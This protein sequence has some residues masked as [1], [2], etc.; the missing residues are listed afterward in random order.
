M[1]KRWVVPTPTES[2]DEQMLM[3]LRPQRLDEYLGQRAVVERLR[4][5][6]DAAKQRGEPLEHTLLYGPPGLGKTTLAHIVANELGV[7]IITTAAPALERAGDVMGYLLSLQRGEVLFVDEVHR[8]ARPVEEFLYPV[9]ESFRVDFNLSKRPGAKPH[10]F[11]LPAF[12]FIGATTTAGRLSKPLRDRFGLKFRLE[13]YGVDELTQIVQRAAQLLGVPIDVDGAQ[14]IARR[15]RGTPRIA[16]RLLRR[17]RDFAQVKGDG[18]ITA[19]VA[20]QALVLEGIDELGLDQL[21]RDYL[22]ALI[23][24]FGGGPAGLEALAALLQEDAR[25]LEEMVEP[26][27]L[28]IGFIQR[29]KQGRIA[30]P[31]A[32]RHLGIEPAAPHQS[33]L[34]LSASEAP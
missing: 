29:T 26:F 31:K 2:D 14:E 24:E 28:Q 32:Y 21:D 27:L 22:T 10:R 7:G 8:L 3:A 11:D 17:V 15:S 9:L 25:T 34:P 23:R 19:A 16:H 13:F 6:I 5:A 33:P 12:T 18:C 20:R 4:I 1:R 30:L